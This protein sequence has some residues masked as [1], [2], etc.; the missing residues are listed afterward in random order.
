M[1][2]KLR[3]LYDNDSLP[4]LLLYGN[5]LVGKKTLLEQLLIYIYKT[6]EN[7]ENNTLILNC[8]LG[9]G[10]IKF[11]R[12]NLRFFANTITHKNITNFK[13]IILLN[14]DSLTLDAQSALRRSIEIYNHT[15]FFIVTANKS[16]IIKP[17]L[18]RFSEIYCN[19]RN[20]DIINKSFKY[21]SNSNSNKINNKLSLIIKNLDNKLETLKNDCDKDNENASANDYKKNVLLLEH[22]SL[23][24]NKGLS[25]NNMLDYFTAKSNFKTDYY[26]FL[27]FF[28]IY[29]RE[30][31]VEEYLIYIILYFYSNAVV[32]D[33]SAL[34]SNF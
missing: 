31:R 14:A 22:S 30:I 9:K 24:Y 25:A 33:F 27:F 7:I 29:K 17:I 26:K 1:L 8:S 20:M 6:N 12:E 21:N 23:I 34:N 3:D 5:N 11:I 28:N 18:S 16:K 10:N 13:S 4:N 2:Q 32:I 19:D 15:K